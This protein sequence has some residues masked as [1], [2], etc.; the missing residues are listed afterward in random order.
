VKGT[1]NLTKQKKRVAELLVTPSE[2]SVAEICL[3]NQMSVADLCKLFEDDTF[4]A[5]LHRLIEGYTNGAAGTVWDA[6]IEKCRS[7]DMRA[8]KLYFDLKGGKTVEDN[9]SVVI[10][11]A[12][13]LE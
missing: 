6:L 13:D 2:L 10:T 7:G 4:T 5:Y 12:D 11:G 3:Q 8:I 9:P 1:A